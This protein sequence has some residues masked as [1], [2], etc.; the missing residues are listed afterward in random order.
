MYVS[1]FLGFPESLVKFRVET[2]I[3]GNQA[4]KYFGLCGRITD[5]CTYSYA[6]DGQFLKKCNTYLMLY[7][8]SLGHE[9]ATSGRTN[10]LNL[11]R[12]GL[13]SMVIISHAG[14]ITG[15]T[16]EVPELFTYFG[17]WAVSG[18]FAISGFLISASAETNT[19]WPDY[20][21]RRVLRIFPAFW[22]NLAMVAFF[23]APLYALLVLENSKAY[24]LGDGFSYVFSNFSLLITDHSIGETLASSAYE[25]AWNGSLWTLAPEFV[26]YILLFVLYKSL[27]DRLRTFALISVLVSASLIFAFVQGIPLL[28]EPLR[29]GI[30]FVAGA[31]VHRFRNSIK[32]HPLALAFSLVVVLLFWTSS[33]LMILTAVPLAYALLWLGILGKGLSVGQNND[34]SYGVYIYA[35][36]VQQF[37]SGLNNQIPLPLHVAIS[38]LVAAAFA[39]ISWF[40]VEKPALR[41]VRARS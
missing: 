4:D 24:R 10:A 14:P 3:P 35:F 21:K 7:L 41:L 25:N 6:L 1:F 27:N 38:L 36:P 11:I 29:L 16:E 8:G 5:S 22:V 2:Q 34:I 12:L 15:R 20:L 18:F 31:L 19:K 17:L 37:V 13:A 28:G 40:F 26:C 9:V 39:A 30:F 33:A 23:F 32:F